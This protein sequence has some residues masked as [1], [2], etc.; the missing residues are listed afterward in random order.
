VMPF[1]KSNTYQKKFARWVNHRAIFNSV[2]WSDYKSNL[3]K[4]K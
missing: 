4:E 2:K 1:D 3:R